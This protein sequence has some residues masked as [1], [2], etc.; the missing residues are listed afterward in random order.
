MH[1]DIVLAVHPGRV[2]AVGGNLDEAVALRSH[3]TDAAGRLV[4]GDPGLTWFAVIEN[5]LGRL[6]PFAATPAP[7]R[8]PAR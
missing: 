2:E 1:C 8:P 4:P 3:P 6:P 7:P 5:R